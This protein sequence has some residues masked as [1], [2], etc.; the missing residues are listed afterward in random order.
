MAE[1]NLDII[2]MRHPQGGRIK[3][4]LVVEDTTGEVVRL[5]VNNTTNRAGKGR[6]RTTGPSTEHIVLPGENQE[7]NI[8]PAQRV[9]YELYAVALGWA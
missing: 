4:Y 9:S 7:S 8:P 2:S 1:V 3:V 6:W 5:G